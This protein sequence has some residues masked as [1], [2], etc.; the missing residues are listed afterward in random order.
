MD[1]L[2]QEKELTLHHPVWT[3]MDLSSHKSVRKLRTECLLKRLRMD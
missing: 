3:G 2:G 1:L